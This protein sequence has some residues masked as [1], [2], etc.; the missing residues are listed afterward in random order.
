MND[1]LMDLVVV[2]YGGFL[3]DISAGFLLLFDRTRILGFIFCGT[4]HSLN[5]QLFNIG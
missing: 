3:L 5:S 4:F 1:S 2:H